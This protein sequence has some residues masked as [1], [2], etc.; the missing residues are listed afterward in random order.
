MIKNI[1]GVAFID[2]RKAFDTVDHELLVSKLACIGCAKETLKWFKSYLTDREQITHFKGTK[3]NPL[4]I[5]MGVPQGSILGPLL[6]SIYV[7]SLPDCTSEGTVDM[8]ADDI[9]LTVSGNNV[10]EVEQKFTVAIQ[11]VMA[12]IKTNRLVLIIVTKRVSW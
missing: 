2:L 12:W 9:T 8:Y 5:T 11:K 4:T 1:S 7:N 10:S 3:S 6:F